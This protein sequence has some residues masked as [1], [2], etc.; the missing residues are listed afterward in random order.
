MSLRDSV[1]PIVLITYSVSPSIEPPLF[2]IF[3]DAANYLTVN[4]SESIN[5]F[6]VFEELINDSILSV[7]IFP[8]SFTTFSIL[9]ANS[10]YSL[11]IKNDCKRLDVENN[12]LFESLISCAHF[13]VTTVPVL[14][15]LLIIVHALIGS[16]K[17]IEFI[18]LYNSSTCY[19]V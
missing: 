10:S 17:S 18:K 11:D 1:S 7:V 13:L 9:S 15:S 12:S 3:K 19:L 2:I 16:L 8:S 14:I 6:K 4:T 5:F